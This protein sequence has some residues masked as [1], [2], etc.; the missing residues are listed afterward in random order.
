MKTARDKFI[1]R[2][3][4]GDEKVLYSDELLSPIINP[5]VV[6]NM[7]KKRLSLKTQ[8]KIRDCIMLAARIRNIER[9]IHFEKFHEDRYWGH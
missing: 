1:F 9:I 7:Y 2:C 4:S 6:N 3:S 8:D 5:V